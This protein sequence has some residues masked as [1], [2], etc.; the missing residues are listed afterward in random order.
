MRGS[1]QVKPAHDVE[2][3]VQIRRKPAPDLIRGGYRFAAKKMYRSTIREQRPG[4]QKTRK[5]KRR[6]SSR[7]TGPPN[8]APTPARMGYR[9]VSWNR[10]GRTRFHPDTI[11]FAPD[12]QK[13]DPGTPEGGPGSIRRM[14]E[15]LGGWGAHHPASDQQTAQQP[16]GST[17]SKLFRGHLLARVLTH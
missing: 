16:Y 3:A 13:E 11:F 1:S 2:R 5:K 15:G 8:P 17:I 4:S 7:R 12:P 6:V 9:A 14:G 10:S